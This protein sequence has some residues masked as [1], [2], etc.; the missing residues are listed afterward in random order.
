M[1][2]RKKLTG[3]NGWLVAGIRLQLYAQHR[4]VLV[5]TDRLQK[6][7][8]PLASFVVERLVIPVGMLLLKLSG[9][10]EQTTSQLES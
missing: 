9:Q 2:G 6:R 7:N 4:N 10:S 5:E 8:I 3:V 1:E